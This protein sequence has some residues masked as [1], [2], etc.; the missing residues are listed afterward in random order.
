MAEFETEKR[1]RDNWCPNV[2]VAIYID[3]K[4]VIWFITS[5][6]TS[7]TIENLTP[8]VTGCIASQCAAWVEGP[9]VE[10]TSKLAADKLDDPAEEKLTASGRTRLVGTG[11]C[12]LKK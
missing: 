1:A 3:A 8:S 7:R 12:G 2:Q 5:R 6:G 9:D 4:G 11:K 10:V